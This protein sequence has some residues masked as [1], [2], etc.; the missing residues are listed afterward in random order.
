MIDSTL[1]S[2]GVTTVSSMVIGFIVSGL[3]ISKFKPRT[4]YLLIWNI[5]IGVFYVIGEVIM[6]FLGCEDGTMQGNLTETG[7]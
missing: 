2:L 4:S 1:F 5:C 7:M 6:M 3:I